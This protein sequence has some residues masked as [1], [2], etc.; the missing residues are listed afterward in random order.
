PA[1]VALKSTDNIPIESSRHLFTSCIGLD[2][3][4]IILLGKT[5]NYFPPGLQLRIDLFNW[6]WP[7]IVQLSLDGFVDYWN[8]HKI[9]TQRN[10]LLPSFHPT[11]SVT[12]RR[13]LV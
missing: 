9:Q 8:N 1:F 13:G 10:K 5:L 2:I 11:T 4:Q 12:F 3:K 6:L 7:K